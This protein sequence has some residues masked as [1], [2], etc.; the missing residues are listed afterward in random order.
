MKNIAA[1][2]S[3]LETLKSEGQIGMISNYDKLGY[4]F[5]VF[6]DPEDGCAS[7]FAEYKTSGVNIN[8]F[9]FIGRLYGSDN[10]ENVE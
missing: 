10:Y 1:I 7:E 3:Y 8:T 4:G 2:G 9:S 6:C 5:C